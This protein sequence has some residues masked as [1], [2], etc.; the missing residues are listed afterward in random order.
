[1]SAPINLFLDFIE[2]QDVTAKGIFISFLQ[3]LQPFGITEDYLSEHLVSVACD[4]ADVMVGN[5]SGV[6]KFMKER[7]PSVNVW[8]CMNH[9]FKLSVSDAAIL[10][11]Q[12]VCSVSCFTKK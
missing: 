11:Q 2:L 12:I 10:Y 5:H 8:N 4:G 6:K 3:H 9:R 1:M 7:F